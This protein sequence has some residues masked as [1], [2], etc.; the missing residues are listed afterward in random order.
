[1]PEPRGI[2]VVSAHGENAPL[3]LSSAAAGTPLYG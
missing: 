3:A 1:M 2:V